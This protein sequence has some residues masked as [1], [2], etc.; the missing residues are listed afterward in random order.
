M[1]IQR[2][3]WHDYHEPGLYMLTLTAE[4]RRAHPFGVLRGDDE[5]SATIE[6]SWLGQILRDEILDQPCR[7]PELHLETFVIMED[8]CHILLR[9]M[10]PMKDHL[11]TVAWGIKYGTTSAYLNE[12]SKREGVTCRIEKAHTRQLARQDK[13][14]VDGEVRYVNPLWGIGYNDRIVMQTGQKQTLMRYISRN[15]SR[16]WAKRHTDRRY[17]TVTVVFF[18]LSFQEAQTLKQMALY[19]DE[20]QGKTLSSQLLQR[21]TSPYAASYEALLERCLRK[22]RCADDNTWQAGL[23]L[24]GCGNC[25]LL[26][27]GRPLVN[28]R[29]SRSVTQ[30]QL[31]SEVERVLTLCERE[32]AVIVSPFISWSEKV[33]LRLLRHNHYPHIVMEAEA[34]SMIDKPKDAM[35]STQQQAMPA[36]WATS[37][38]ARNLAAIDER[39]D[40]QCAE[41]GEMLVVTPWPDYPESEKPGKAEM[42]IMNAMCKAMANTSAE[43]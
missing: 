31:E 22:V 17:V 43:A 3:H 29:I 10:R 40:M 27:C 13:E 38:L 15:P 6:L 33:V 9:V 2:A 14:E 37:Q 41:Q 11:G 7:H 16:L 5:A 26:S 12:M 20:H 42:E 4:D 8:H 35:R 23:R 30:T 24:R 18:P 32:G 1:K 21:R 25:E 34:M 28:V 39:S 36:W 19:A